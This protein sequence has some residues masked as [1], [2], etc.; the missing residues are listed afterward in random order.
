MEQGYI[1][2]TIDGTE[3]LASEGQSIVDA[4][5]EHRVDGVHRVHG[6][7]SLAAAPASRGGAQWALT[8]SVTH[9]PPC[10]LLIWRVLSGRASARRPRAPRG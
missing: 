4:A 5:R 8:P 10:D 2:V 6:P 1:K 3:L 9:D 7:T